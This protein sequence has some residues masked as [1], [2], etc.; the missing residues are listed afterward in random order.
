MSES[1]KSTCRSPR[2]NT[3]EAHCTVCHKTF[4]G[5]TWFDVHRV[6]GNCEEVPGLVELD[7]LWATKE[8][9][10][11]NVKLAEGMAEIRR[12]REEPE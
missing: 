9:H 11:N 6:R 1:C 7:G 4:S 3:R 5:P 10:R 2:I 8:R 12:L